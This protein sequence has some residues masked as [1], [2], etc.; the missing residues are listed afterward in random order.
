MLAALNTETPHNVPHFKTLEDLQRALKDA[1]L[2]YSN[3]IF[4]TKL[5]YKNITIKIKNIFITLKNIINS[6]IDYTR[7]NYYQ[8]EKTFNNNSLHHLDPNRLNP[9]QEVSFG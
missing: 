2:E 5:S 4:G 7:S 9:Y 1:G 3:L 8:G 6:G